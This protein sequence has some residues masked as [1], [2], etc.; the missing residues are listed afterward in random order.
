MTLTPDQ[1]VR[2][3]ETFG[4]IVLSAVGFL[5]TMTCGGLAAVARWA[6]GAHQRRMA[7]MADALTTLARAVDGAKSEHTRIWEAIQGLRA[8]L[9]LANRNTDMVKTGLLKVEGAIENQRATIQDYVRVTEKVS[10]KLEAVFRFVD[11]PRRA[12]DKG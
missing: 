2:L 10:G 5:L 4:P 6:W 3:A 9:Q 12:T 8:E 7:A 1:L 11:S